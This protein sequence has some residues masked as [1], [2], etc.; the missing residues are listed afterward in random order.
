MFWILGAQVR[1][2]ITVRDHQRS[3][4]PED[5]G[6]VEM[7]KVYVAGLGSGI[8]SANV[9]LGAR[10]MPPLFCIPE[11]LALNTE[12]FMEI[13]NSRIEAE[14]K[15]MTQAKL[16]GAPIG[17]LLVVGLEVTFPCKGK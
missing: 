15:R 12:N 4:A 17:M 11:N 3:L 16:D 6:V 7:E 9:W 2:E 10:H 14:S 1:A 13:L 8:F 5:K